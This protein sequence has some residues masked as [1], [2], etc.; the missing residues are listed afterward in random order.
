M[1][2]GRR[3]SLRGPTTTTHD[4]TID[5]SINRSIETN[6]DSTNK[7]VCIGACKVLWESKQE[8]EERRKYKM[9]NEWAGGAGRRGPSFFFLFSSSACL[10]LFFFYSSFFSLLFF[11]YYYCTSQLR[12]EQLLL[13]V[14]SVQQH[15]HATQTVC[16]LFYRF[17][18]TTS[19]FYRCHDINDNT[20]FFGYIPSFYFALTK[21]QNSLHSFC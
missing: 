9:K 1:P 14:S 21:P 6:H 13:P 3:W 5:Q 10:L 15:Q 8:A 4:T 20:I 19:G 12:P 18:L 7:H 16:E 11:Y 17:L 2:F